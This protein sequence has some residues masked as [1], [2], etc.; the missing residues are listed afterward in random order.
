MAINDNYLECT[1]NLLKS[2]F[3]TNN[4]ITINL[5]LIYNN[6]SSNSMD[7]LKNILENNNSKLF[8]YKYNY[9]N[10]FKINLEHISIETYYR[11][12]AP[13]ILPDNVDKVLYL[14]GDIICNGSIEELYNADLGENIIGACDNIDINP[15][16]LNEVNTRLGKPIDSPYYNAGVLLIDLNKYR[17][18]ITLNELN[19]YIEE[20]KDIA[21]LQDQDIL[22]LVFDKK[23]KELP[24]KYNYLANHIDAVDVSYNQI[25]FHYAGDLKPW[26]DNYTLPFQGLVYYKYLIYNGEFDKANDLIIKHVI[27]GKLNI[28]DIQE[29][30]NT[31][32]GKGE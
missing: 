16:F 30:L 26:H 25:L 20:Y 23:I 27:N 1:L 29:V 13:Y 22:N 3:Q 21:Y 4:P 17:N 10:D 24:L 9:N 2:I 12:Y 18:Y 15:N 32:L 19:K 11:L 6:L 31:L 7:K 14:D 8:A 5:Y 28:Y